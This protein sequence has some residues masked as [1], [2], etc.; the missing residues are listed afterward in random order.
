M[1][2]TAMVNKHNRLRSIA[3]CQQ[4]LESL[5]KMYLEMFYLGST[6]IISFVDKNYPEKR[7]R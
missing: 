5:Q 3:L 2:L 7:Y 6:V 4:H 1:K